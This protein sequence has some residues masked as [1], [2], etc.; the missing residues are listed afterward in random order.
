MIKLGLSLFVFLPVI[1]TLVLTF[2]LDLPC[3]TRELITCFKNHGSFS[4]EFRSFSLERLRVNGTNG[5]ACD[6]PARDVD[7]GT[8]CAGSRAAAAAR[9]RL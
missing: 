8:A 2:K 1:L 3:F 7:R 5:S 9:D 6:A 4:Y